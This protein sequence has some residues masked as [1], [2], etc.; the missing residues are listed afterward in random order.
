MVDSK[1][2]IYN[3]VYNDIRIDEYAP[4]KEINYKGLKHLSIRLQ[5]KKTWSK[6]FL[7]KVEYYAAYNSETKEYHN[8]ILEVIQ[9]YVYGADGLINYREKDWY[10]YL[11]DGT[12]LWIK[13][14]DGKENRFKYYTSNSA[15][16]AE[17]R[18]R[19]I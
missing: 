12:K 10:Y 15:K 7:T 5:D 13:G 4:P 14:S 1:F 6:G 11:E 9:N 3:Y 16:R 2:K 18:R 8:I 19:R 17:G